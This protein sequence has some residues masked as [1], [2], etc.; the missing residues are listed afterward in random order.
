M[1]DI[2]IKKL[3]MRNFL[4]V[5]D[6]TIDFENRGLVGVFGPNGIGKSTGFLEA[7]TCGLFGVSERY[8][9]SRDKWINRFIGRDMHLAI[10]MVIDGLPVITHTYRKHQIHKDEVFLW[11]NGKDCRGNNNEQTYDKIVRLLDMDYTGFTSGIVFG[12][13]ISQYFSALND[14]SQKEIMERLLGITWIPV[15]YELIKADRDDYENKLESTKNMLTRASESIEE[16]YA[17]LKKYQEKSE[18]FETSRIQKIN[19]LKQQFKTKKDTSKLNDELKLLEN[20]LISH[21]EVL[22]TLSSQLIEIE[23]KLT[24]IR[25]LQNVC[26]KDITKLKNKIS[27]VDNVEVGSVCDFCGRKI[28]ESSK[29]S[30][31][32]HLEKDLNEAKERLNSLAEEKKEILESYDDLSSKRVECTKKRNEKYSKYAEIEKSINVLNIENAKIEELNKSI[33][34]QIDDLE[35]SENIWK[36]MINEC[37]QKIS[38][39]AGILDA[40]EIS[41][42]QLEDDLKY[43]KFWEEGFSNK[44]LKSFVIESSIPQMN[45]DANLYSRSLGGKY[46][47]VF[48]PQTQL[49]GGE[50]REKFNVEVENKKG[51]AI[52]D[53][54]S[55]GERRAIDSI[56]MFVLGDLAARRSNKRFTLLILDDVFE[57]LDT[58]ICDSINNI[59]RI[60]T[61]P[62]HKRDEEYAALP[63]RESI[64]VLTHLEYFQSKFENQIWVE[65]SNDGNTR[66]RETTN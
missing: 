5:E 64:F 28:T 50:F 45:K 66:Y 22:E 44:G 52:Y 7:L 63:E 30:Y 18:E 55:N 20:V 26:E 9:K 47:I 14:S 57:K 53:G 43:C 32:R 39:K 6:A 27:T 59:L 35:K 25:T 12:Q 1:S 37:E 17:N 54:N 61:I 40:F 10:E 58:E 21:D 48:S 3:Y 23:K 41:K 34:K 8:G 36:N 29:D 56:V 38:D 19:S 16:L 33:T 31:K 65:R 2:R 51:S 11:I 49:K 4:C 46:S 24:E 60:M 42:N 15:A 62:K 13:A